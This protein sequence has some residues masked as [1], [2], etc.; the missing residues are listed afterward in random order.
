MEYSDGFLINTILNIMYTKYQ[1]IR[2]G[3]N[4]SENYSHKKKDPKTSRKIILMTLKKVSYRVL[5]LFHGSGGKRKFAG[6][7]RGEIA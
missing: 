1:T 4:G 6:N 7:L 3:N 2:D 5:S